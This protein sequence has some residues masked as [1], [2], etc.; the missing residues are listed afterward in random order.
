MKKRRFF[1]VSFINIRHVL[2][3][4]AMTFSESAHRHISHII[5][6]QEYLHIGAIKVT[7]NTIN[8]SAHRLIALGPYKLRT[9][10]INDIKKCFFFG[11]YHKY[12]TCSF[13]MCMSYW[14]CQYVILTSIALHS[15]SMETIISC[16]CTQ[17]ATRLF[18]CY[19][20]FE[21]YDFINVYLTFSYSN[22]I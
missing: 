16:E 18:K 15:C 4:C 22:E 20:N 2:S 12:S 5:L 8:T 1:W 3:L 19:C 10:I 11:Y 21:R 9:V 17:I 13:P 6:W 14:N 7:T